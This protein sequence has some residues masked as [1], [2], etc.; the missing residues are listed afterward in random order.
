MMRKAVGLV[1]EMG[2]PARLGHHQVE[3]VAV[4]DKIPATVGALMDGLVDDLDA[5]E[6]VP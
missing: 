6:M 3:M 2:E 4:N 1:A 5:A